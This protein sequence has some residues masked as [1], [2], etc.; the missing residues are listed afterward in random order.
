MKMT[1]N[2]QFC[3]ALALVNQIRYDKFRIMGME[4]KKFLMT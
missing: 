2:P 3:A 1:V 4:S